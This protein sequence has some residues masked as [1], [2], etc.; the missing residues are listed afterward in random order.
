MLQTKI[1][2][3]S[4]HEYAKNIF[5]KVI[6]KTSTNAEAKRGVKKKDRKP[7]KVKCEICNPLTSRIA[8]PCSCMSLCRQWILQA[9][10]RLKKKQ[11][12]SATHF[13]DI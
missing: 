2:S 6:E 5:S 3:I 4:S 12:L 10:I 1:Y 9:H 7:E 8:D 13:P 11:F